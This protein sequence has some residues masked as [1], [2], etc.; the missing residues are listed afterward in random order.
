MNS[1]FVVLIKKNFPSISKT[2]F[3]SLL[4]VIF[5][6]NTEKLYLSRYKLVQEGFCKP[7]LRTWIVY[8][9]NGHGF[10]LFSIGTEFLSTC[11]QVF[12]SIHFIFRFRNKKNYSL[13]FLSHICEAFLIVSKSRMI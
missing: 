1:S 6:P 7:Y 9:T 10:F 12:S 2:I 8:L 5:V 13:Q 11:A 3:M 4:S